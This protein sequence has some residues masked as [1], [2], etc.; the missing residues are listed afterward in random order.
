MK[1]LLFLLCLLF[2]SVAYAQTTTELGNFF[3]TLNTDLYITGQATAAANNNLTLAVAG[4]AATD[5]N[6]YRTVNLEILF[7]GTVS[8]GVVTFE[9]SADNVNFNAVSLYDVNSPSNPPVTNYTAAGVNRFW[10][11]VLN[12]RYFRARVSTVIGGGGTLQCFSRFS[13][14]TFTP[15]QLSVNINSGTISSIG[16]SVTPGTGATNL[17]KAKA[18]AAGATD[19]G[20][21]PLLQRT[22]ALAAQ[23]ATGQYILAQADKVGALVV[24]QVDH[25]FKTYSASAVVTPAASA[26]DITILPGNATTNVYVTRVTISGVQTTGGQVQVFLI[27]RSTA[28]TS[29]TSTSMTS[30]VHDS[31]DGAANSAVLNYSANPTPGTAVGNVRVAYAIVPATTGITGAITAFSFADT[32]KPITLIGTAQG[33]AVNLN[34]VTVTGGVFTVTYEWYEL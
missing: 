1:K 28:N 4:A 10:S 9:G 20:I 22:D 6:G 17:G 8:S 30:V 18:N 29:G 15:I 19:T 26:T 12:Y 23:G 21:A 31:G 3:A 27:K 32:G 13:Q 11:G 24:H 33:L 2:S 16:T 34:G 7:S 5:V 25:L 14:N